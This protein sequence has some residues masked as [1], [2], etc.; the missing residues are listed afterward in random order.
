MGG[1]GATLEQMLYDLR[2]EVGQSTNPA[3]SRSTR[4]R[5]ITIINRIQKRLWYDYDWPFL[6]ITKDVQLQAGSRYYDFPDLIDMDRAIKLQTRWGGEWLKM[7][8][9]IEGKHYS[10]YNSDG[11][12]GVEERLDPA[13][14]WK[15]YL[16]DDSDDP[17]F[18]VWPM[19]ASNG[20]ESTL[21]GYVRV[22][23][24]RKLNPLVN[25]A[26]VC[27]LDSDMIV[28]YAASEILARRRV[29]DAQ[30]KLE[31]ANSIYNRL[32]GKAT[33][34]EPFKIGGDADENSCGRRQIELRVAYAGQQE[35]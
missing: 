12:V 2:G 24:I 4:G 29:A 32:K 34:A 33:P 30:A 18:E 14:R 1:R 23:G 7:G 11:G 5:F 15:Y 16:E 13:W 6:E 27:L 9:G 19:P 31:N 26:D 25:D 20:V 8:F 17:Q 10:Q 22:T 35:E 21:E 3:V 28:L